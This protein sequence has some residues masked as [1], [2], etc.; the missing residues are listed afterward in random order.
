MTRYLVTFYLQSMAKCLC[1]R[2]VLESHYALDQPI[3]S[4]DAAAICVPSTQHLSRN[5]V[6]R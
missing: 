3:N 5:R 4:E 1:H 6:A 2:L